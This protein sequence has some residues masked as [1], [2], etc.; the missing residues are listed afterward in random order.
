MEMMGA[1]RQHEAG[2]ALLHVVLSLTML[3]VVAGGA[4]ML[5]RV[6]VLVSHYQ[7]N[8]REALYGAQA[9][10]AMALQDLAGTADWNGVLAG[11]RHAGFADGPVTVPRQIPGAGMVAVCCGPTSLTGRAQAETGEAWIPFGWQSLSGLIDEPR[12]GRHYLIAWIADDPGDSD[13]NPAA[14]SNDRL[15]LRAESFAPVGVRKSIR[16]LI[17]RAPPD[18]VTGARQP[19]LKVLSWR[20]VR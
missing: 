9:I 11:S 13:G 19:G 8:E 1:Q 2:V 17:S 14:D 10:A 15:T 6:E 20:E 12:A 4:A 3:T 5:A 7:H 18:P 16:A